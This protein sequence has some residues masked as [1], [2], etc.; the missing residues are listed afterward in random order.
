MK[1]QRPI[2]NS[3]HSTSNGAAPSPSQAAR[4]LLACIAAVLLAAAARADSVVG[5]VHDWDPPPAQAPWYSRFG[6]VNL[7][8]PSSGG[9]GDS[10]YLN[11]SFGA[12]AD[13]AHAFDVVYVSAASLFAGSWTSDMWVDFQF[14]TIGGAAP[15]HIQ[16]WWGVDGGNTWMSDDLSFGDVSDWARI[17]GP[18]FDFA[19]WTPDVFGL[20][21]D[22]FLA[23]LSAI[24]WI[25]IYIW[26]GDSGP[27]IYGIDNFR[28][29]IPEPG[30]WAMLAAALAAAGMAL[31]R[32]LDH[33][34]A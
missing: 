12:S 4:W 20:D 17:R 24:D 1:S 3:Q 6:V 19:N 25:G 8:T 22:D 5:T 27:L 18:A 2:F 13:P 15:D 32:R 29:M 16:I 30:E 21:G 34:R 9:V 7:T 23:D 33:V 28:L 14:K 11:V 10:G 31:R 26:R